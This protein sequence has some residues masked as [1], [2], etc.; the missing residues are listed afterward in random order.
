MILVLIIIIVIVIII[1]FNSGG[2]N[3]SRSSGKTTHYKSDSYNSSL[4]SQNYSNHYSSSSNNASKSTL[5]SVSS[6]ISSRQ[7]IDPFPFLSKTIKFEA[8]VTALKKQ[9]HLITSNSQQIVANINQ[10]HVVFRYSDHSY[11][12]DGKTVPS[13]TQVIKQFGPNIYSD[14]P[15]HVLDRAAAKGTAMHDAIE[16]YEAFGTPSYLPEL[17]GYKYLKDKY[18]LIPLGM[19]IMVVIF[20]IYNNPLCAGRLDFLLYSQES[21][22]DLFIMDLK[23]T[24]AYHGNNV[25]TQ[26]N[27]YKI[28]FEQCYGLNIGK[29]I[30]LRLRDSVAEYHNV[31]IGDMMANRIINLLSERNT[32]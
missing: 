22:S 2:S 13:I 18:Q 27:L 3:S 26:L 19:E 12:V 21:D 15:Q 25:T 20:D 10:H 9:Y 7:E 23:R 24:S 11:S 17:E 28:G 4:N 29:L 32:K 14:V 5:S 31:K 30:C 16:R 1:A 8:L 6:G